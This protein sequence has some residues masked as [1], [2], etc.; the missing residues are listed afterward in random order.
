MEKP[1]LWPNRKRFRELCDEERSSLGMQAEH[2]WVYL[3]GVIGLAPRSVRALYTDRNQIA[4]HAVLIKTAS[5]FRV[6]TEDLAVPPSPVR[7]KMMEDYYKATMPAMPKVEPPPPA[8]K[9]REPKDVVLTRPPNAERLTLLRELTDKLQ[10]LEL[11]HLRFIDHLLTP[12]WPLFS[13]SFR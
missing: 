1:D 13:G 2:Y 12:Y 7:R 8:P 9:V 11:E 3:G 5:H 4:S 6:K 10:G